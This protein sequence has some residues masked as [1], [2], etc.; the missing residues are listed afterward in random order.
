MI[1]ATPAVVGSTSSKPA[2]SGGTPRSATA[3][4]A[5]FPVIRHISGIDWEGDCWYFYTGL[6]PITDLKLTGGL[7]YKVDAVGTVCTLSSFL[8]F[9]NG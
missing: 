3:G 2:T 4:K 9:P 6:S 8:M 7:Q 1:K 5:I